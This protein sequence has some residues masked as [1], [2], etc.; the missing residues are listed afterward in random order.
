MGH[1]HLAAWGL[2]IGS[3]LICVCAAELLL[4]FIEPVPRSTQRLEAAKRAGLP[5]DER[6]MYQFILDTRAEGRSIQPKFSPVILV[7]EFLSKGDEASLTGPFPLSGVS[8]TLTAGKNENG[9]RKIYISDRFGFNNPPETYEEP[10]E[11]ALI[12]DSFAAGNSVHHEDEIAGHLRASGY[13]VLNLGNGGNGPLIELGTLIEY[14]R[15]EAPPVVLWLFYEGNDLEDLHDERQHPLLMNYLNQP[16]FDQNLAH[17]QPELDEMVLRKIAAGEK[18]ERERIALEKKWGFGVLELVALSRVRSAVSSRFEDRQETD[19]GLALLSAILTR[20]DEVVSSWGGH[21]HFVYLPQYWRFSA[22]ATPAR[23]VRRRESVIEAV[24]AL[25]I[26]HTDAAS[27]FERESSP[28][29]L[30]PFGLA[31]HYNAAGY[32]VVADGILRVL[33]SK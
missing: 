26:E 18:H 6:K 14:A 13:N 15:A 28:V 8:N 24:E 23:L 16:E 27:L 11:V 2:V 29:Q 22:A 33:P 21:L 32:K 1:R 12:G 20:A 31:G 30:F 19:D 5:V 4:G 10:V 3:S 17:R 9:Y 25:Q 7:R